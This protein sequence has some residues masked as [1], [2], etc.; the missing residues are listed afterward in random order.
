MPSDGRRAQ[1][2]WH[3]V[4]I[5]KAAGTA[6]CFLE[7]WYGVQFA[8]RMPQT[9]PKVWHSLVPAKRAVGPEEAGLSNSDRCLP[10]AILEVAL[11]W[12]LQYGNRGVTTGVFACRY[13]EARRSLQV[14]IPRTI[15]PLSLLSC[16]GSG[17]EERSIPSSQKRKATGAP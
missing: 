17:C 3:K 5:V 11:I 16:P 7:M 9:E 13:P 8:G 1:W 10:I 12:A 14:P 4:A 6:E 2:H 15:L